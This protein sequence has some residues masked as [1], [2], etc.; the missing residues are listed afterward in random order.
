MTLLREAWTDPQDFRKGCEEVGNYGIKV[1]G[2][3][4]ESRELQGIIIFQGN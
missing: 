3:K 4:L 1:G 2:F